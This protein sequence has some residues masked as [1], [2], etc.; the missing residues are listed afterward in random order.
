[1][2]LYRTKTTAERI[3]IIENCRASLSRIV[4]ACNEAQVYHDN[5]SDFANRTANIEA[6]MAAITADITVVRAELEDLVA[7]GNMKFQYRWVVGRHDI[8]AFNLNATTDVL[9]CRDAEAADGGSAINAFAGTPISN[10]S[11]MMLSGTS[12]NDERLVVAA[13]GVADSSLTFVSGTVDM[14][15]DV[16]A[17]GAEL[18][19]LQHYV[20]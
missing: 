3:R 4:R 13:A 12:L 17:S 1:M 16:E 5:C 15:E 19:L 6:R 10:N 7:T 8:K 2:T 18:K 14:D 11:V 9:E 20:P